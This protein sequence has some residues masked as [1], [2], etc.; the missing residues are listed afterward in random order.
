MTRLLALL[1]DAHDAARE[2]SAAADARHSE[3]GEALDVALEAEV[4]LVDSAVQCQRRRAEVAEA[5]AAGEGEGEAATDGGEGAARRLQLRGARL[6]G[7]LHALKAAQA[8]LAT[9]AGP[10]TPGWAGAGAEAEAEAE[11]EGGRAADRAADVGGLKRQRRAEA[12]AEH[13]ATRPAGAELRRARLETDAA[14][15]AGAAAAVAAR[16]AEARAQAAEVARR[17]AATEL[18]ALREAALTTARRAQQQPSGEDPATSQAELQRATT[19]AAAAA[20]AR[21]QAEERVARVVGGD[22]HAASGGGETGGRR[23]GAAP[24]LASLLRVRD[25][26]GMRRCLFA[27]HVLAGRSLP[28]RVTSTAEQVWPVLDAARR[29]GRSVRVWPLDRLKPHDHTQR[30]R[31]IQAEFGPTR[32]VLPVDLL[33]FDAPFAPAV[34]Q[35]VGRSLLVED[36]ELAAE[37]VRRHG[38]P[39]VSFEGTRHE[40][41]KMQGGYHGERAS[42][43]TLLLER[44]QAAAAADQAGTAMREAAAR[45]RTV[46]AS[47]SAARAASDACAAEERGAARV[48]EAAEGCR[49]MHAAALT[50]QQEEAEEQQRA[51]CA[52]SRLAALEKAPPVEEGKS[53]AWWQRLQ[54][55]QRASLQAQASALQS[56]LRGI[57]EAAVTEGAMQQL[58][59]L[60]AEAVEEQLQELAL[61]GQQAAA[62]LASQARTLSA[63]ACLLTHLTYELMF[64]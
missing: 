14:T 12:G 31:A 56:E 61:A 41:G 33:E 45:L 42:S 11:V 25:E 40:K 29:G 1:G 10:E 28:V 27:L 62:T 3:V 58:R 50:A 5:E 18:A 60:D 35:A 30:Q 23:G 47:A 20:A 24:A 37:I 26:P 46:Q 54:E 13:D 6:R 64:M 53:S 38:V 22:I 48:R 16:D 15:R 4:T 51:A 21:K 57:C 32:V 17:G 44:Q 49:A 52:A 55:Q 63:L 36:D 2:A 19:A 8:E 7:R 43:F 59:R 34:R 39:C 9:S